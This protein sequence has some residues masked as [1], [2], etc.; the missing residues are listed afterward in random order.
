MLVRDEGVHGVVLRLS[1]PA[2][3]QIIVDGKRVR[4]GTGAA[5]SALISQASRHGLAGL[6]TLIGVPGTVGGGT[7]HQRRQPQ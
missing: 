7:A 1:E 3:T 4:A 6:E 5:V 2:F